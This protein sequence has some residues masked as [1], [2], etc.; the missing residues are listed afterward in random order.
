MLGCMNVV[1]AHRIY[2]NA[3]WGTLRM[4]CLLSISLNSESCVGGDPERCDND[5]RQCIRR[6]R[7]PC[8][9]GD[10][11]RCDNDRKQCIRR[12]HKSYVKNH[13]SKWYIPS[14][15]RMSIFHTEQCDNDR[16]RCIRRV[17]ESCVGGYPEFS[18]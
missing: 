9:G 14:M 12:L 8:V 2:H 10:W 18:D 13:A 1:Q 5:R 7:E 4:P 6:V 15:G 16:N 17:R 3:L 11:E